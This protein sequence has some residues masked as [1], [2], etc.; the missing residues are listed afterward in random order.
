[1]SCKVG[2]PTEA[3]LSSKGMAVSFILVVGILL[4]FDDLGIS[5]NSTLSAVTSLNFRCLPSDVV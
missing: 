3:L 5:T 4:F 1:M 2:T